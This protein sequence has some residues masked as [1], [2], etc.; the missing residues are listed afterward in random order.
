[1]AAWQH[2][3]GRKVCVQTR[4][5]ANT[6]TRKHANTQT[7]KHAKDAQAQ[8]NKSTAH[9][10]PLH[11]RVAQYSLFSRQPVSETPVWVT[12]EVANG[13]NVSGNSFLLF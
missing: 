4:K 6:Q 2:N 9:H 8:A 7:R 12:L 3:C 13:G 5:H 10:A 1:M 11:T